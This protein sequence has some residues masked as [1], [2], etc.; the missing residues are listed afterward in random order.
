MTIKARLRLLAGIG[1]ALACGIGCMAIL[2][3]SRLKADA[4]RGQL[5][6]NAMRNHMECDMMHD[7]LRADVLA[8]RLAATP[9]EMEGVRS[10]LKDHAADFRKHLEA[11]ANLPLDAEL[12]SKI[13]D[14]T[15]ALDAYI[16]SA[17]ECV[18][19]VA[20]KAADDKGTL[21][22]ALAKFS[23]AFSELETRN[24]EVSDLIDRSASIATEQNEQHIWDANRDIVVATL[25][26]AT[27]LLIASTFCVRSIIRPLRELTATLSNAGSATSEASKQF[28]TTSQSLAQSV[29]EQAQSTQE[30]TALAEQVDRSTQSSA[31]TSSKA[32]SMSSDVLAATRDVDQAMSRMSAAVK[33]IDDS[34]RET[35]AIVKIINEIAFQTN[36][37]ALN[38]AVEAAR[39][40]EAGKGFAVVAEEVRNLALRS[41]E[42]AHKTSALIERS[43]TSA[44]SGSAIAGDVA[45]GLASISSSTKTV[46]TLID[47]ISRSTRDQAENVAKIT[48]A[49]GQIDQLTQQNAAAAEESASAATELNTQAISVHNCVERLTAMIGASSS[50][51]ERKAA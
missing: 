3:T 28:T 36:L 23:K 27:S 18:Q 15:P 22:D 40:G 51:F 39:A 4:G 30:T 49:V 29:T 46:G 16:A 24:S 50:S 21:R 19:L 31:E 26:G 34:A 37:L 38:A 45:R 35:A 9:E 10:D 44:K 20:N 32:S 17:E 2:I 6:T 33:E 13:A 42:A 12:K 8:A 1:T 14:L 48:Q 25:L 41:G 47:D 5:I 11:N 7:A 43:V